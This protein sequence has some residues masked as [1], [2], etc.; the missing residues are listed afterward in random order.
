MTE[1]LS[2]AMRNEQ[3]TQALLF[4]NSPA[5]LKDWSFI[6]IEWMMIIGFVLTVVH[7]IRHRQQFGHNGAVLTL[8]GA[9]LYG[10]VMD[11]ISYYTV[12]N[13]WHGEFSV[14]FLYN[15]LP[16][17]IALF[18]PTF[19]YHIYMTIQ[20]YHFKPLTEAV[21]TG[22]FAGLA[23][24]IFDNFGPQVGWWIW[25]RNDPTTWPYLSSVPL[26]SY[27]WFFLFTGS[28]AYL[29]RKFCW[30]WPAAGKSKGAIYTGVATIPVTT[31]LLGSVLF[32]PYNIFAKNMEPWN[33]TP[34]EANLEIAAAIHAISFFIAGLV[35]LF[36]Y[37]RPDPRDK[38]LMVF[39]LMWIVGHLFMYVAKFDLYF[40]VTPQGM[41]SEGLAIG[42][43]IAAIVAIIASTA[44]VLVSHPVPES[45]K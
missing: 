33:M 27:A 23:Y 13:F 11:I 17:Y 14:M 44:I 43:L 35:F 45:E 9:L 16:L 22:F 4:F 39:P 8:I 34:W 36:S 5:S 32:I 18:Y 2:Y 37:R 10:L 42:N 29:A 7:A 30:D 20:R 41:T 21:S 40:T 3:A 38:L 19:I 31:I 15:R 28:F 25:D 24:L 26:T 12:E 1:H 6:A